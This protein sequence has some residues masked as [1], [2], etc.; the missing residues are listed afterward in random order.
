M[1]AEVSPADALALAEKET[2]GRVMEL[3]FETEDGTSVYEIEVAMDDGSIRELLVD[4][5]TGEITG[6]DGEDCNDDR[7]D[8]DD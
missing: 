6:H 7:E 8:D 4:A 3:E 1:A 5:A 2:G